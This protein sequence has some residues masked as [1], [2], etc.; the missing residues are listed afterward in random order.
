MAAILGLRC[1]LSLAK[2]YGKMK[3]AELNVTC[4]NMQRRILAFGL[5]PKVVDVLKFR[6]KWRGHE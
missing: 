6:D 4:K 2:H 1:K 5:L 3:I